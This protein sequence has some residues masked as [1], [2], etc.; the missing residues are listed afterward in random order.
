MPAVSGV[1]G[2]SSA[3]FMLTLGRSVNHHLVSGVIGF[4]SACFFGAA[5]TGRPTPPSCVRRDRVLF[6]LLLPLP[7]PLPLPLLRV[8]GV[9]GF[10]SACFRL[11]YQPV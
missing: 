9:I 7:L 2:F 11:L 3:C 5:W 4:S 10:S 1:I 8:S 6:C